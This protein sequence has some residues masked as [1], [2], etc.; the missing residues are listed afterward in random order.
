MA[1]PSAYLSTSGSIREILDDVQKAGVPQRFTYEF[2]KQL[3]HASSAD[4]PA[5]AV[6]KALR[7]LSDSLEPTERYRRFKDPAQARLV[8]AE[9]L[10]DAYA[11]VFTVDQQA[12]ERTTNELKG[13]FARLSDKGDAV[14]QKMASTFKVLSELADFSGVPPPP[15]EVPVP[16]TAKSRLEK[17]S[18]RRYA[19]LQPSSSCTMTS[20]FTCRSP[21]ISPYMTLSSEA[22]VSI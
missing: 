17:R 1:V 7:F 9:A 18:R 22:F 11:D 4:R 15:K 14:N 6:L 8:M 2:L 20:T 10:R 3:G 5:V 19:R 13:I 16:P 21:R 12:N